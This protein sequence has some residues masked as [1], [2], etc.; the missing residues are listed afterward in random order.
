[1]AFYVFLQPVIASVLAVAV[2]GERVS[3]RT[4]IAAALVFA[5]LA[6]SLVSVSGPRAATRPV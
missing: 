1:V 6:V 4:A 2:L 3:S 5:G